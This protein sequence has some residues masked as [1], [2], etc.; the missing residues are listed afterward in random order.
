MAKRIQRETLFYLF[1][2]TY[3][4]KLRSLRVC[5]SRKRILIVMEFSKK[6]IQLSPGCSLYGA[7]SNV[8]APMNIEKKKKG[9]YSAETFH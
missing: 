1:S 8:I 4:L 6:F 3:S 5:K 7:L 9:D 2:L